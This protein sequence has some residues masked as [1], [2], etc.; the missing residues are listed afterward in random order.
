MKREVTETGGS[1]GREPNLKKEEDGGLVKANGAELLL[2]FVITTTSKATKVRSKAK[3]VDTLYNALRVVIKD[4]VNFSLRLWMEHPKPNLRSGQT[5]SR[6]PVGGPDPSTEINKFGHN[7]ALQRRIRYKSVPLFSQDKNP[8]HVN[9]NYLYQHPDYE[10]AY[11]CDV[12][13]VENSNK[14]AIKPNE[15]Y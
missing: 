14:F 6:A 3:V 5:K 15:E 11:R 9:I 8:K 13:R 2:P 10:S 7:P 4:T 12:E 1:M